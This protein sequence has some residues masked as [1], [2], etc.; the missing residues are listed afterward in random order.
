LS[1][2]AEPLPGPNGTAP[3]YLRRVTYGDFGQWTGDIICG[4]P[5]IIE[6]TSVEQL[7][8]AAVRLSGLARQELCGKSK[9]RRTVA[10]RDA[11]IILGRERG[12]SNRELAE[13]LGVDGSS[14]TKRVDAARLRGLESA[15]LKQIRKGLSVTAKTRKRR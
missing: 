2:I 8:N 9:N 12:L 11:V 15:E 5:K 13:A 10:V 14:V 1:G 6:R 7:L 3:S 4:L